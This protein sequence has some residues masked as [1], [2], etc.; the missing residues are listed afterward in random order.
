M[1][2][3]VLLLAF[4]CLDQR[5]APLKDAIASARTVAKSFDLQM[6][7][8]SVLSPDQIG[9]PDDFTGPW[10]EEFE[11]KGRIAFT[12]F[13]RKNGAYRNLESEILFQP[14]RSRN[15]NV[16][17]LVQTAERKKAKAITVFTHV[18][19]ANRIAYPGG[20][21]STLIHRS[22]APVLAI[23]ARS[24][25]LR[26]MRRIML[27]TDLQ[28]PSRKTFLNLIP[29]AKKA[30]A[31]I[32]LVHVLPTFMNHSLFSSAALAG[33][34]E[35]VEVFFEE[36]RKNAREI[37]QSWQEEAEKSGIKC[38]HVLLHG[39]AAISQSLLKFS[40][41][42]KADLV[43]VSEKTGPFASV[44]LGSVTRDLLSSSDIP[45]LIFP[46]DRR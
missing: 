21:V 26:N 38:Q 6:R 5:S 32:T 24:P 30:K 12:Q 28:V 36:E 18:R 19:G 25:S 44:V 14:Y 23:N 7:A 41:K 37:A 27:A 43:V 4:D 1:S 8:V 15:E 31:E 46:G 39:S 34:W 10:K 17:T 22:G 3:D 2:N 29:F 16:S 11:K 45:V 9:W 33:G 13:L 40:S 20:F 42:I 35:N